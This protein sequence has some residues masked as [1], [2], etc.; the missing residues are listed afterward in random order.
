M[1]ELEIPFLS[2]NETITLSAPKSEND[3]RFNNIVTLSIENTGDEEILFRP[4]YQIKIF[5]YSQE[6]WTEVFHTPPECKLENILLAPSDSAYFPVYPSLP[7]LEEARLLR[8]FVF[9]YVVQDA[10][11]AEDRVGGYV[12]VVLKP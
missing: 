7:D 8:F 2:L 12:D 5:S 11:I 1:P 9:G 6:E 3:F 10:E 4:D